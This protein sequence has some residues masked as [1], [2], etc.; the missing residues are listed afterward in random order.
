MHLAIDYCM[1]SKHNDLARRGDHECGHHGRRLLPLVVGLFPRL[2][3]CAID[4]G[5]RQ[6]VDDVDD[7]LRA[8]WHVEGR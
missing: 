6:L 3:L 7:C 2:L 4:L 8:W 1:F 5:L